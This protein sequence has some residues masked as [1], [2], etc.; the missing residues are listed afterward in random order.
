MSHGEECC[1]FGG[2]FAVKFGM[3]SAA[4]GDSKAENIEATGA[5]FV[6]ATD[7]SCLMHI[8]GILRKRNARA[9]TMPLPSILAQEAR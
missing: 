3:I 6:T 8:E 7:P 4:M 5:E 1:G 2:T 9:R